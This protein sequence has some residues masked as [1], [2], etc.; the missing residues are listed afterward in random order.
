MILGSR[1]IVCLRA[2][3]DAC[4]CG[5]RAI[6][7]QLLQRKNWRGCEEQWDLGDISSIY[8]SSDGAC[9]SPSHNRSPCKYDG[10]ASSFKYSD[11]VEEWR[12][13]A[14][15]ERRRRRPA[16]AACL[17]GRAKLSKKRLNRDRLKDPETVVVHC[18]AT[19]EPWRTITPSFCTG[20]FRCWDAT[21]GQTIRLCWS[22]MRLRGA[23]LLRHG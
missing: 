18:L 20:S 12:D 11:A 16:I 10:N 14:K 4:L 19:M 5:S 22:S 8:V 15:V 1:G 2:G 9:S 23:R 7:G 13:L 17:S 21:V 6:T 3:W